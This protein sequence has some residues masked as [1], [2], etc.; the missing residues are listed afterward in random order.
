MPGLATRGRQASP[1]IHCHTSPRR[2]NGSHPRG[3]EVSGEPLGSVTWTACS[4]KPGLH[5]MGVEHRAEKGEMPPKKP[6][7]KQCHQD[8]LGN[9]RTS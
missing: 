1:L 5:H 9:A 3:A 8:K 7:G 4:G 2:G 6:L